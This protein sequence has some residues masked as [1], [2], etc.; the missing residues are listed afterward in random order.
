MMK[1]LLIFV[2]ISSFSVFSQQKLKTYTFEEIEKLQLEVPKPIV[3]FIYTNNCK[4]CFAMKKNTF[5][6]IDIIDT[7]N[8]SFYFIV[9]NAETKIEICFLGKTFVYKPNGFNTG[10][11]ELAIELAELNGKIS[12]PTLTILNKN[13]EIMRQIDYFV[14]SKSLQNILKK[15]L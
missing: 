1:N 12:Y 15:T 4:F 10:V 8:N 6:N 5:S 13:Y 3:I 11:H 9:L 7:L 2:F 14:N